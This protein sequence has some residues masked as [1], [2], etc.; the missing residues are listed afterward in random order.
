MLK[1]TKETTKKNFNSPFQLDIIQHNYIEWKTIV[2]C[3]NVALFIDIQ[4]IVVTDHHYL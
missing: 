2:G 4:T 1:K 3:P